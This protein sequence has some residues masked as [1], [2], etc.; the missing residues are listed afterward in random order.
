MSERTFYVY[1]HWRTDRQECFYVGKGHGR[2]AYDMRRGRNRWHKF[3]QAKLSALGTTI[4]IKIVADGLTE[5]EAFDMEVQRIAFWRNDGADLCNLTLGGDGPSG[6]RHTEEWKRANSE[7][8]KRRIV[9]EETRKKLAEVTKG[10][11]RALGI[12]RPRHLV[13]AL[14]ARNTGRIV[15]EDTRRKMSESRRG[16]IRPHT[17][18]EDARASARQK[19]IPKPESVKANMRGKPKSDSHRQKLREI[20]LGKSHSGETR[21]KLAE[22]SRQMWAKR[23]MEEKLATPQL[24]IT[25]NSVEN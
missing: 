6:R 7:R 21:Q 23:R 11:K 9:S 16:K 25:F 14:I 5:R 22:I 4:E 17:A 1:E 19:G 3:L 24:N 20:N 18:E 13:E 15:S 2:R 10:N 8:M 12:K